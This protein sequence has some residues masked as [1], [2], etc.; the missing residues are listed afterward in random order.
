M[1]PLVEYVC[2]AHPHVGGT[3]PRVTLH[4]G[5]WAVCA[6]RGEGGHEWLRI[7]PTRPDFL[8]VISL[9]KSV[10]GA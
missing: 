8:G 4:E 9:T 3:G 10:I 7:E 6:G 1:T 2:G 5:A